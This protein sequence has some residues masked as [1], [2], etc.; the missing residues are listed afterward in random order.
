MARSNRKVEKTFKKAA[1]NVFII[2]KTQVDEHVITEEEV[3][4][5]VAALKNKEQQL[6]GELEYIR[7]EIADFEEM[8]NNKEPL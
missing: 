7:K 2:T 6:V 4:R 1:N 5:M 3:R 8:L